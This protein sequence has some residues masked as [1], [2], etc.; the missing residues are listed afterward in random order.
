MLLLRGAAVE[1]SVADDGVTEVL[2]E[3]VPEERRVAE[4]GAVAAA[5]HDL[6]IRVRAEVAPVH[7]VPWRGQIE[8]GRDAHHAAPPRLLGGQAVELRPLCGDQG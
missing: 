2:E 7:V 5:P 8:K 4:V 1:A 3:D 6:L